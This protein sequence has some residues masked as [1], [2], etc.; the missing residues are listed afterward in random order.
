MNPGLGSHR[1]LIDPAAP[2]G[3][4][5]AGLCRHFYFCSHQ[6][7]IG[8]KPEFVPWNLSVFA[9]IHSSRHQSCSDAATKSTSDTC[10]EQSSVPA[11][12]G[13]S[14]LQTHEADLQLLLV[15]LRSREHSAVARFLHHDGAVREDAGDK[16][17]TAAPEDGSIPA[18]VGGGSTASRLAD[19]MEPPA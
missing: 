7:R 10:D 17:E 16:A 3:P 18:A 5:S 8:K 9:V 13:A 4:S 12:L 1:S 14:S 11:G 2:D 6:R 15:G 19:Q